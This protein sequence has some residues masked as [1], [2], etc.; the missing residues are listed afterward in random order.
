MS[1][2][3]R[4]YMDYAATTPVDPRVVEAMLPY[5]T[6]RFGNASSV[7]QFGQEAR[8]AVERAREAVARAIG[9][10]PA[11]IVFT[12]GATE[13]DNFA[14]L[15]TAWAN[16]DRGRHII[17]SAVEHHA[18]LEPCRFL[19][20]RGFEVTYLPVDRYGRVDPDDVRRAIRPDTILISVMHANNE[21]GTLQ[22]VAEIARLGRERGILVHT[23]ATQS[24]GILPVDVDDLGV[25]LLSLSAHKRYGPKG[26]G[27][28]FIRRGAR[29]ARIQHGGAHERN[30]RAGTENVPGIVGLGAALELA[31]ELREDEAARLRRLRDRLIAGL[32]E[33]EGARLNGHPAERLP[34]NVNVSFA[35]TDSESLLLALDLRGVAASS[36]SACTAGSLE[37]SHVL[38]AIGLPPE[39]AAGTLRLS[40]GRGT[41]EQDVDDVLALMPEIVAVVRR[42]GRG[43]RAGAR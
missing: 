6:E 37:P 16:E 3:R 33:I 21:I 29:V 12:S 38:S 13:S 2:P 41:T 27:A 14:I 28:L 10:R 43:A 35:G 39:V 36:G 32:L 7:H 26:V 24:V 4:I 17:T 8:E 15:G 20:S 34:G 40:L 19:E 22:P 9:A 42:A 18:V 11:E 23:D 31:M 25:D 1:A 5:F 30:R